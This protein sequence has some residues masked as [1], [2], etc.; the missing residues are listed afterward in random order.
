MKERKNGSII[1]KHSR[2][3]RTKCKYAEEHQ[4]DVHGPLYGFAK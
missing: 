1:A 4:T 2:V 3:F